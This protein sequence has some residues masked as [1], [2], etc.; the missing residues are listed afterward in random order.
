VT[1]TDPELRTLL[2]GQFARVTFT[3][4]KHLKAV[5]ELKPGPMVILLDESQVSLVAEVRRSDVRAVA[6]VTQRAIP[7]MYS[8]PIVAVV[9]R[10][11]LAPR[12]V[13]A[14]QDAFGALRR[15]ATG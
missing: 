1:A 12:V 10:P 2:E 13:A 15:S 9:E 3:S 7:I 14:L 11:L 4:A 5:L 6:L 8:S